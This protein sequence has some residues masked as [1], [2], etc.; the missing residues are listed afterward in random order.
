M[1]KS[2]ILLGMLSIGYAHAQE[3]R[4]GIN[5]ETP[6]ATLNVKT[7]TDS[8]SPKNLELESQ[9]GTKLLTVLNSGK[10]GINKPNPV[11]ALDVKPQDDS[12]RILDLND[13]TGARRVTLLNSGNMGINVINPTVSLE[14]NANKG[15]STES[16]TKRGKIDAILIDTFLNTVE[17]STTKERRV[18]ISG[19][20]KS[21]G[22]SDYRSHSIDFGMKD[23]S[24]SAKPFLAFS[25]ADVP[26]GTTNNKADYTVEHM[27]ITHKGLIGIGTTAPDNKLHIKADANPLKLEGLQADANATTILVAD[28]NGVVKTI[29]KSSLVSAP[30]STDA[31][32]VGSTTSMACNEANRGKMNFVKDV[33]I[34]SGAGDAFAVCLKGTDGKFYW[35]YL[36]GA[37]GVTTS[38]ENF[39]TGLQ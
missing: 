14:V 8:K 29:E 2:M 30:V 10:V 38:T 3:E 5:T 28:A 33:T 36:Y 13:N 35:R 20:L 34:G 16:Q 27:R 12:Y 15:T 4:V 18:S 17:D 25:T 1:K 32:Q 21:F 19:S 6:S 24:Y 31:V 22:W 37:S 11:A 7:Q 9:A 39:G 26:E 23:I